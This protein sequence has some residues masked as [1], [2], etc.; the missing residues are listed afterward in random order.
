V[1]R[2]LAR[3]ER[4]APRRATVL[5][6]GVGEEDAFV[7]DAVN[8]RRLVSHHASVVGADVRNP[9]IVAH[10]D[11]DVGFLGICSKCWTGKDQTSQ[12]G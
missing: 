2:T 11:E 4:R 3:D 10:D 12:Q 9:A 1:V 5:A 6:E 7:G 8:I